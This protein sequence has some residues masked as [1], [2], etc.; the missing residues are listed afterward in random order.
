MVHFTRPQVLYTRL[1]TCRVVYNLKKD[2]RINI[3][4]RSKQGRSLISSINLT[5][6]SWKLSKKLHTFQLMS[7]KNNHLPKTIHKE[8]FCDVVL[9]VRIFKRQVKLIFF[10]QQFKTL[11]RHG[12]RA[13]VLST[14]S[15]NINL[16][17]KQM[18]ML[19]E[20]KFYFTRKDYLGQ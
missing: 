9:A 5:L 6:V 16:K 8:L 3:D 1:T 14:G 17:H 10:V 18:Q 20:L 15:I 2:N 11:I 19:S 7:V 12:S 13:F 4:N